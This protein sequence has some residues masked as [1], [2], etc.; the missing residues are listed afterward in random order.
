MDASIVLAKYKLLLTSLFPHPSF[1]QET[2]G[3]LISSCSLLLLITLLF[4]IFLFAWTGF[5]QTVHCQMWRWK[6]KKEGLA[7][8]SP[9]TP[10]FLLLLF[11]YYYYIFHNAFW[12][13][14]LYKFRKWLVHKFV[15]VVTRLMAQ[16]SFCERPC[17]YFP[18]LNTQN[19]VN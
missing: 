18:Q 10:L 7:L 13:C 6:G 3:R 4:F 1:V 14:F 5:V 12:L 9:K 19:R 17:H 15:A 2:C 16:A 8:D 11:Y